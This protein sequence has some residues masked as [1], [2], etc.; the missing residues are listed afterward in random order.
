MPHGAASAGASVGGGVS[1][2]VGAADG[3]AVGGVVVGGRVGVTVV[4]LKEKKGGGKA[5]IWT[6]HRIAIQVAPD[7]SAHGPVKPQILDKGS[8]RKP[9]LAKPGHQ[10][11]HIAPRVEDCMGMAVRDGPK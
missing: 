7:Q 6:Q 2:A 3:L 10:V 1:T 8:D 5:R 11:E 4:G 9:Q